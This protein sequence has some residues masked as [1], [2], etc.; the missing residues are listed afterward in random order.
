MVPTVVP[1]GAKNG[2]RRLASKPSHSSSLCT[3]TAPPERPSREPAIVVTGEPHADLRHRTNGENWTCDKTSNVEEQ[4]PPAG[5]EPAT[6]GLGNCGYVATN[7][8]DKNQL[9]QPPDSEVPSVVPS[10]LPSAR[11]AEMARVVLAW[12][13]LPPLIRQAILGMVEAFENGE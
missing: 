7:V 2:A 13:S 9:G 8:N 6:F 1:R 10:D 4:A 12:P 11:A 5:F 3:E